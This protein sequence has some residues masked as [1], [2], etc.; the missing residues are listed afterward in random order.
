MRELDNAYR[1]LELEPGASL[2]AVNQAYKDL[3]FVWHPDRIPQDNERLYQKAQD[4]IKALNQARD[5]LRSHSR[6][7]P[8]TSRT[9]QS[10]RASTPSYRSAYSDSTYQGS[11]YTSRTAQDTADGRSSYNRYY[12]YQRSTYGGSY[13]GN[14]TSNSG[15]GSSSSNGHS[16]SGTSSYSSSASGSS[17]GQ[18]QSYRQR[19][20]AAAGVGGDK[21]ASAKSQGSSTNG[22]TAPDSSTSS[23]TS[24][25]A[26]ADQSYNSYNAHTRNGAASTHRSRQSPDLSGTDMHGANLREKDFGGRNLSEANLSGADLSDAFL[27]KVNL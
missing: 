13:Y 1:I 6:K 10:Y 8:A 22:K 21:T 14:G 23:S 9:S 4:K 26:A 25:R 24:S 20:D 2:E 17:A 7:A 11:T 19:R 5:L 12:R 27:H 18:A 3:V 16:S 15:N